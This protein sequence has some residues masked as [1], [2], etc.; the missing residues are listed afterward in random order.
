VYLFTIWIS[1]C[2]QVGGRGNL[3]LRAWELEHGDEEAQI[4]ITSPGQHSRS[5]HSRRS[6]DERSLEES[7]TG[8]ISEVADPTPDGMA[9]VA[10]FATPA[11]MTEQRAR[12]VA[13]F[14]EPFGDGRLSMSHPPFADDVIA[15]KPLT[16]PKIFGPERVVEDPRIKALHERLIRE[17]YFLALCV[18]VVS[19]GSVSKAGRGSDLSSS[20]CFQLSY[21][22]F[23]VAIL[24]RGLLSL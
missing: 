2:S 1:I 13:P 4:S 7:K 20:R 14:V 10:P 15:D 9:M 22:R 21:S 17:M 23:L 12:M 24:D 18:V 3:Q 8:N 6:S 19:L 11:S 5:T 16:R